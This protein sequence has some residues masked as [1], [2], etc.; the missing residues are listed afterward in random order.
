MAASLSEVTLMMSLASTDA[1]IVEAQADLAQIPVVDEA[2]VAEVVAGLE[3][4]LKQQQL[5][6]WPA[7]QRTKSRNE[8]KGDGREI[9]DVS[10]DSQQTTAGANVSR[11]SR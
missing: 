6:E 10:Q 2:A 3:V 9:E 7:L 5:P 1:D 11:R 8:M 4:W